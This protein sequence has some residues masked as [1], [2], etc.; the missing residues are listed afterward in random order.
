VLEGSS[1]LPGSPGRSATWPGG[2]FFTYHRRGE[3]GAQPSGGLEGDEGTGARG[4]STGRP[5]VSIIDVLLWWKL[6]DAVVG[7]TVGPLIIL[8]MQRDLP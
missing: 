7:F 5:D 4:D 2:L 8:R 6:L 1:W 3:R